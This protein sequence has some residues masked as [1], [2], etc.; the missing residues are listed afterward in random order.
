VYYVPSKC[1]DVPSVLYD[2][3]GAVVC[4]PDGGITG[5]GDGRCTDF[6]DARRDEVVVWRDPRKR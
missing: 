3:A 5:K 2:S 1:C 6:F 4:S